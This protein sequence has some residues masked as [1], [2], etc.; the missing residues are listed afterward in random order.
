MLGPAVL[1]DG[2]P[3]NPIRRCENCEVLLGKMEEKMTFADKCKEA[4]QAAEAKLLEE[5]RALPAVLPCTGVGY[6]AR[7]ALVATPGPRF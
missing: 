1:A 5:V 3:V 7:L 4:D 6:R 2:W